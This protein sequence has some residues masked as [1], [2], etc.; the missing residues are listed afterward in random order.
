MNI[1]ARSG[2]EPGATVAIV[3]FGFLG[4]L[5]AQLA[6]G[7]GARVVV[8][9]RREESLPLARDLGVDEAI[10]IPPGKPRLALEAVR[11]LTQGRF[12]P[13]VVEVGGKQES[14]DLATELTG[15]RGRL[16]IAGYH[17]D[18][19]R[20]VNMQLW[21]WRGLD[22]INAHEREPRV[23]MEGMRAAIAAVVEGRIKPGKLFTHQ[24]P[25][26]RLGEALEMATS[27][28]PGFIKALVLM[29]PVGA[30]S[31]KNGLSGSTGATGSRQ[32]EPV[33]SAE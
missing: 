11:E 24:F 27:R 14:L 26:E 7:V 23:Y 20:Q 18:G 21:N 32:Q 22:V 30:A 17:Q 2:I 13:V 29:E 6:A 3:G 9:S 28:P 10:V 5:L 31:A 1:F 8:L 19:T 33:G 4:A 25:L 16:V 15:E 12:C